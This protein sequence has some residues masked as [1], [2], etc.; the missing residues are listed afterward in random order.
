[1][2]ILI[3][4]EKLSKRL[5]HARFYQASQIVNRTQYA[6]MGLILVAAVLFVALPSVV[7]LGVFVRLLGLSF[8]AL[9]LTLVWGDISPTRY[10]VYSV[11][12]VKPGHRWVAQAVG[13]GVIVLGA[14]LI[15]TGILMLVARV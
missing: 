10:S 14:A 9:G 13:V 4:T 6:A 1:M 12:S 5:G 15:G 2:Q 3:G 11:E 8:L 7:G